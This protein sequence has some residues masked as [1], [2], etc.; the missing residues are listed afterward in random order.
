MVD[1]RGRPAPLPA[2]PRAGEDPNQPR[3]PAKERGRLA[4]TSFPFPCEGYAL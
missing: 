3:Q 1:C 2:P 4:V